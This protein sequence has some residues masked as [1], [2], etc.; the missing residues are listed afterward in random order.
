MASTSGAKAERFE[1]F[2]VGHSN[3]SIAAFLELLHA[4][5]VARIADV[6]SAPWSRRH[7]WFGRDALAAALAGAGIGYRHLPE[8]GG[9]RAAA[10]GSRHRALPAGGFRGYADHMGSAEFERGVASLLVWAGEGRT[11]CM[12]AEADPAQCHRG[13]L[14]DAL[15]ARGIA[16]VHLLDHASSRSH[17][18][19]PDA[20]V[21]GGRLVY[22]ARPG[23]FD[24]PLP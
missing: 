20:V 11:A 18:L 9:L 14:A 22:P 10:P 16:V 12:C 6:R 1:L 4:H 7:P 17:A 2:T 23:L 15:T 13:L 5:R 19:H 3:R 8:L 24:A 21:E